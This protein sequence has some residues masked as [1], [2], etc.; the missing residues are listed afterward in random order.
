MSRAMSG[1]MSRAA[2]RAARVLGAALGFTPT[3]PRLA[4]WHGPSV[5]NSHNRRFRP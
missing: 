2:E 4:R 1:A 3:A 5:S